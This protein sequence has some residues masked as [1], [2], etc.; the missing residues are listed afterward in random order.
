MWALC[1]LLNKVLV[2]VSQFFLCAVLTSCKSGFD[3]GRIWKKQIRYSLARFQ[4]DDY[5]AGNV[6]RLLEVLQHLDVAYCAIEKAPD[7]ITEPT[8]NFARRN[9]LLRVPAATG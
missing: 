6:I 4:F 1:K 3:F 7:L 9:K 8:Y 2:D 5:S